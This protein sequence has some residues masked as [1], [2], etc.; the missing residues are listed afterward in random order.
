MG[1]ALTKYATLPRAIPSFRVMVMIIASAIRLLMG[2]VSVLGSSSVPG[3]RTAHRILTAA[4]VLSA[5]WARAANGMFAFLSIVEILLSK[6][7]CSWMRL[8][9]VVLLRGQKVNESEEEVWRVFSKSYRDLVF[10]FCFFQLWILVE[11]AVPAVWKASAI[12]FGSFQFIR[13]YSSEFD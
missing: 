2:P 6:C 1:S 12:A 4:L 9:L 13:S 10:S 5:L 11:K 7:L 3:W 8:G